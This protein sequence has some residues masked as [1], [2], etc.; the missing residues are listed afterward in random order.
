MATTRRNRATFPQTDGDLLERMTNQ[1]YYTILERFEQKPSIAADYTLTTET[2]HEMFNQRWIVTGTNATGSL[3]SFATK[4]GLTLTTAAADGDNT[5]IVAHTTALYTAVKTRWDTDS[6][7]LFSLPLVTGASVVDT[8]IYAGWKLTNDPTTATDNDQ[9]FFRFEGGATTV[10]GAG[11]VNSGKWQAVYSIGGTDTATDTGITVAAS[12]LY[13]LKIVLDSARIPYFYINDALVATG[14][15]L[16]DLATFECIVG[17]EVDGATAGAK[18]IT[19][20][21]LLLSQLF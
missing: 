13:R 9:A 14:T 6:Q 21:N 15:A 10:D 8:I 17:V 11:S 12:T 20:R 2:L 3:A 1:K 16:T 4:G 7:L 5:S 18:A 19:L